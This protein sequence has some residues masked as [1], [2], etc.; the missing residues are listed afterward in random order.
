[1]VEMTLGQIAGKLMDAGIDT[2]GT[3]RAV[4]AEAI[5]H[6]CEVLGDSSDLVALREY[7]D[8]E[9]PDFTRICAVGT[10]EAWSA[11]LSHQITPKG[12]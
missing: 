2:V 9:T 1:M 7:A 4:V 8:S 11:L 3:E 10:L 12:D 5:E 6:F